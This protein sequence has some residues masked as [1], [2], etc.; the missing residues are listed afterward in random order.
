MWW[1]RLIA[2]GGACVL[3]LAGCG[4]DSSGS[5]TT[6]APPLT[7]GTAAA[8]DDLCAL[9][10]EIFE[11]DAAPSMEQLQRY[12]QLAPDEIAGP[13]GQVTEPLIASADPAAFMSV[14]AADDIEAAI[15]VIDAWEEKTCGI[16]H[17]EE[18]SLPAGASRELDSD[19]TRVDVRATDYAFHLGD[20]KPGRTSFVLTNDGADTHEMLIVKLADGVT[21]DE[22][23]EAD[24]E[25]GTV[26]ATW[27]TNL[28]APGGDDEVVTLDVEPGDY[29]LVCFIPNADGTPHME[30]GMRHEFTV[31]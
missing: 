23:I 25:D 11:Q 3:S 18:S 4:D 12:Q 22:A 6:P 19:A 5:A 26:V 7:A 21:L 27:E 16:P 28:A 24:G 20:V 1:N 31:R 15:E 17:S 9:A 10:T 2:V 8:D 14:I 30:L 29:A 13:V